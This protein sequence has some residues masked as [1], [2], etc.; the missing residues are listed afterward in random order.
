MNSPKV[1]A[2]LHVEE[3]QEVARDKLSCLTE[4][5]FRSAW[6]ATDLQA[7]LGFTAPLHHDQHLPDQ[8]SSSAGASAPQQVPPGAH[9]GSSPI[10]GPQQVS[11]QVYGWGRVAAFISVSRWIPLSVP[12]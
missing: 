11:R 1:T 7:S 2:D 5:W 8:P 4:Q 3:F 10:T 12:Q 9:P 6:D